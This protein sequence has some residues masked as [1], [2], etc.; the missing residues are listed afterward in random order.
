MSWELSSTG[1]AMTLS[2]YVPSLIEEDFEKLV[3]QALAR[4]GIFTGS[5][6]ALGNSSGRKKD[7]GS[8]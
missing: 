4:Q 3:N 8:H 6:Y 1:F 7:S 5:D 2:G